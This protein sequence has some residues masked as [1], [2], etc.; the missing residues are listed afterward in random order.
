MKVIT[1]ILILFLPLHFCFSQS[2][3]KPTRK[4][5]NQLKKSNEV[6][7]S[8][9]GFGRTSS[10][11]YKT[12][13]KLSDVAKIDEMVKL[14]SHSNKVIRSYAFLFLSG[15][16]DFDLF[17]I[18]IRHLTDNKSV[19]TFCGCIKDKIKVGDY[20]IKVAN[21]KNR[22]Y[23][24]S[25][26]TE[27]QKIILDS[28]LIFKKNIKL[29]SKQILLS[30]VNPKESYHKRI[31]ELAKNKNESA[32]IALSKFKDSNDILI[33]KKFFRKKKTEYSAIYAA[34]E[35]P[36]STFYPF[37]EKIFNRDI[38]DER[39]GRRKW[40][41]LCQ[42]LAR[43]PSEQTYNFFNQITNT[44]DDFRYQTLCT[45]LTIAITKYPNK[46]YSP[47]KDK[48]ELDKYHLEEVKRELNN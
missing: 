15:I 45:F 31:R 35:F 7:C 21:N 10:E 33:I 4:I 32:C 43:Y 47:L 9:I 29:F 38:K 41:I 5:V 30:R 37:L 14:T 3:S 22:N 39:Y 17:P 48:I 44:K 25:S 24:V 12:Y 26:M 34:K 40:K 11:H 28:S 23:N 1:L 36:D 8:N 2:I 20:F 18:I 46:I 13:E 6:Q 27:E 19:I 42:A 16:K